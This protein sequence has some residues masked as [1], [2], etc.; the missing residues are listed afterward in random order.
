VSSEAPLIAI[1]VILGIAAFVFWVWAIVD[2]VKVPDDS[3]FKAGNKLI[4]VLVIVIAGVLGAIIYLV[5]GRPASGS[6][7]GGAPPAAGQ[8]QIPPPPPGTIG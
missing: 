3:M 7:P 1:L 6:Q 5:V 2:V 4:W 8:N